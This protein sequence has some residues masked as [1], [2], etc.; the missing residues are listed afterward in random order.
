MI[1]VDTPGDIIPGNHGD[2][3]ARQGQLLGDFT[4]RQ[5]GGAGI[6]CPAVGNDPSLLAQGFRQDGPQPR[7]ETIIEARPASGTAVALGQGNRPL[8]QNLK[9][10]GIER[11]PGYEFDGWV[12]SITRKAGPCSDPNRIFAQ[13]LPH[14]SVMAPAS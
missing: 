10:Q 2:A 3:A 9:N 6:G 8:G 12:D 7:L 5:A 1:E 4:R 13:N 14:C 11:S